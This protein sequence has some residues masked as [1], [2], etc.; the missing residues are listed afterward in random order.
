MASAGTISI[1]LLLLFAVLAALF[2]LA[3]AAMLTSVGQLLTH[4]SGKPRRRRAARSSPPRAG[5]RA[6]GRRR[7]RWRPP[8]PSASA[9]FHLANAAML[10]SVG[11]LLTHL[12]GKDHA[13]SLIAICIGVEHAA[14][15]QHP[16]G[17]EEDRL[18]ADRVGLGT[19][20][21][22]HSDNP[23]W[24]VGVQLLDGVGA[25]VYGALFPIVVADLTRGTG[26]FR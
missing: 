19:D 13:T 7:R 16:E 15:G 9:L 10:T 14:Q 24:L 26:R 23:F 1:A 17:G 6:R 12:S 25:G 2:H 3:N 11:Q 18:A 20:E 22:R 21:H 4:L 5:S 8:A